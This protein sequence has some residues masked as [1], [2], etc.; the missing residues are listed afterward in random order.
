MSASKRMSTSPFSIHRLYTE[1]R[2]ASETSIKFVFYHFN[3]S[4]PTYK[5]QRIKPL[6]IIAA[7]NQLNVNAVLSCGK[8]FGEISQTYNILLKVNF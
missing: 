6:K 7:C 1:K 2:A 4:E 8:V 3:C 5:S